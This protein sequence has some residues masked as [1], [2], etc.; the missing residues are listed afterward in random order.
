MKNHLPPSALR[1]VV[2]PAALSL[3]ALLLTLLPAACSRPT[4]PAAE[5]PAAF[6]LTFQERQGGP[7]G[8]LWP[9]GSVAVPAQYRHQP[10]GARQGRFV[11]ETTPGTYRIFT[12]SP[13]PQAVGGSYASAG[14]YA[15]GLIPVVPPESGII[16]LD[17]LGR[18]AFSLDS[19]ADCNVMEAST[20][21]E[22]VALFRTEQGYGAIDT[23]GHVV[24]P[25]EY[26]LLYPCSNGKI[27]GLH[28]DYAE[29]FRQRREQ[30]CVYTVLDKEGHIQSHFTGIEIQYGYG[31][32]SAGVMPALGSAG[33]E[34]GTGLI[35]AQGHWALRPDSLLTHIDAVNGPY[36]VYNASGQR[37]LMRRDG[38]VIIRPRYESL[39]F[40]SPTR[41]LAQVRHFDRPDEYFYLTTDGA[42]TSA[43]SYAALSPLLDGRHGFALTTDGQWLLV[44]ADGIP[45]EKPLNA[46]RLGLEDG[47]ERWVKSDNTDFAQTARA[48]LTA[49]GQLAGLTPGMTGTEMGK[50]LHDGTLAVSGDVGFSPSGGL[51]FVF[52]TELGPVT[53][54]M[55]AFLTK[56][57]GSGARPSPTDSLPTALLPLTTTSV[58]ALAARLPYRRAKESES[59]MQALVEHAQTLGTLVKKNATG[60]LLRQGE[61]SLLIV[62]DSLNKCVRVYLTPDD[63]SATD[64]DH[65]SQT[66]FEHTL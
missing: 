20:F 39:A 16:Y 26:F 6:P 54:E 3:L 53:A 28:R 15:D 35:D 29:A 33:G 62:R 52:H 14:Y 36:V 63:R 45:Q 46:Y 27:V 64:L 38:H 66:D 48:L 40:A 42:R 24:I 23:R 9:D 11:V 65:F 12:L 10:Y 13:H 43:Y 58:K 1:T 25:P 61:G 21:S 44:D 5:Q 32:F 22:G 7:W 4:Y 57:P 31:R 56:L 47:K 50:R 18:P 8:L 55:Q 41:L 49:P 59:M 19:L 17:T 2:R 60:A 34:R 37:G 30:E 51:S